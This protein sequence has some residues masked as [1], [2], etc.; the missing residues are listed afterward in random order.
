[1]E[2]LSLEKHILVLFNTLHLALKDIQREAQQERGIWFRSYQNG[3]EAYI[4]TSYFKQLKFEEQP[5]SISVSEEICIKK[6]FIINE[7]QDACYF[8][9]FK[10]IDDLIKEAEDV[11]CLTSSYPYVRECKKWFLN[12]KNYKLEE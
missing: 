11:E 3:A 12:N 6:R 4:G 2:E 9:Y 5:E 1:M 10:Q 8:K 7:R